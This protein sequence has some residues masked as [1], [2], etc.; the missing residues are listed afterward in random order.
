MSG[1]T[2]IATTTMTTIAASAKSLQ[3]PDARL[4]RQPGFLFLSLPHLREEIGAGEH[5]ACPSMNK[6]RAGKGIRI[7]PGK[8]IEGEKQA[9]FLAQAELLQ[10]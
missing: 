6:D 3:F 2:T 5:L 9:L 1:A 8:R 7:K 4:I 10:A